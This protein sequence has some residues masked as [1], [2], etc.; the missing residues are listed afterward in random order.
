M[1]AD[2]GQLVFIVPTTGNP[3]ARFL[4]LQEKLGQI[5]V[6][7]RLY[8]ENDHQQTI[9]YPVGGGEDICGLRT[10]A[11]SLY[12]RAVQSFASGCSC[13]GGEQVVCY[14]TN[15]LLRYKHEKIKGLQNEKDLKDELVIACDEFE[16]IY[17]EFTTLGF[18]SKE[19]LKQFT[20]LLKALDIYQ[21]R[22]ITKCM[23]VAIRATYFVF[24]RRNKSWPN[25]E[26][27]NFY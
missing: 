23:E 5:Y 13:A 14:W 20:K 1:E 3:A 6:A 25:P 26:L 22:T 16:V 15:S 17:I 11:T 19:S 18:I 21:D 4:P 9:P 12:D 27:L 7:T 24:C 2:G 10:F 8:P